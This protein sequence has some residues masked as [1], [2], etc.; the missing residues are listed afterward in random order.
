MLW[1]YGQTVPVIVSKV[2]AVPSD[3]D[4]DVMKETVHGAA[5]I[6]VARRVVGLVR[7][8]TVVLVLFEGHDEVSG[9][10]ESNDTRQ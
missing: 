6:C 3:G 8:H 10:A 7:P 1:R 9:R 2:P 4:I 5:S